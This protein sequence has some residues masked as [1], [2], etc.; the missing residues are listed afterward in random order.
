MA[1]TT[2]VN[3]SHDSRTMVGIS[4]PGQNSSKYPTST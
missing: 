1:G 2:A 3:N 4:S